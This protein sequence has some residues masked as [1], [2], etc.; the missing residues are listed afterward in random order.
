MEILRFK[1]AN[2]KNCFKCLRE[3]PVKAI[4]FRNDQAEILRDECLICGHCLSV[5]PQNAKEVRGDVPMVEKMF[6]AGKKVYASVAPSFA[7]AFGVDFEALRSALAALGFQGTEE[8]AAGAAAVSRE[9]EKLLQS[10]RYSSLVSTAC[11]TIVK[12]AEKYYPETL[13]YLAPVV[14]PMTAHARM[15]RKKCGDIRV[16]FIGP[17]ISKKDEAG[18]DSDVDCV[19]TFEELRGWLERRGVELSPAQMRFRKPECG[20]AA[21]CY[22]ERGGILK[23]M[24]RRVEG[25]CYESVEGVAKCRE[26]LKLLGEGRLNGYFLEMSGCDGSCVNGPCMIRPEGGY[27]Q[28]QRLVEE[29]ARGGAPQGPLPEVELSRRFVP[30]P[31]LKPM[32]GERAIREILAKM[33]KEKP[34]QELNCSACGYASCREKAVAVYQGKAEI[35]MCMPYMRERAE[36]ISNN[37]LEFTPNAIVVLDNTLHIQAVNQAACDMFRLVSPKE[38]AG[39]Y[40]G[41]MTDAALFEEALVSRKNVLNRNIY[42]YRYEKYVEQSVIFVPGQN[43]VFG[44]LR[45]MTQEEEQ[46]RKLKKVRMDTVETADSV[47]EKQMRVVQEIAMLLGETTAETKVALTKLKET[48]LSKEE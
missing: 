37:V 41:E 6:A 45:D 25:I 22:P 26:V 13:R 46:E 47:I 15:L 29:F 40:I 30:K 42:L 44:I 2:C 16:V 21:R 31:V 1:K 4:A 23:T 14:S 27:L 18:W 8:T 19:L 35:S 10:G 7:A 39:K 34:E 9:Y 38:V 48:M 3:C 33:G 5:C 24:P 12:L 11:P 43:F 20:F 17:C 36:Y 32:P 28:A